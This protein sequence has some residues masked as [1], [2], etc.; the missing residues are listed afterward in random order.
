MVVRSCLLLLLVDAIAFRRIGAGRLLEKSHGCLQFLTV[1]LDCEKQG[2]GWCVS[3]SVVGSSLG[4][5]V[6]SWLGLD[7]V[8]AQT[9]KPMS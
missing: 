3:C 2:V 8:K 4:S 7:G 6:G 9:W 5:R 1:S